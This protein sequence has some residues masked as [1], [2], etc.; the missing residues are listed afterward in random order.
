M[1]PHFAWTI[2][3]ARL[4]GVALIAMGVSPEVYNASVRFTVGLINALD[5]M[6]EAVRRISPI[7]RRL[8][9]V[10]ECD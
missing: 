4:Q 10:R 6:D 3:L 7:V 5:E 2:P 1:T 9:G 8:R